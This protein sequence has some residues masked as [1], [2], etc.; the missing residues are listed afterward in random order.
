MRS[1][2]TTSE[3][4]H[5]D[6]PGRFRPPGRVSSQ[7]R[8]YYRAVSTLGQKAYEQAQRENY[9]SCPT[10]RGASPSFLRPRRRLDRFTVSWLPTAYTWSKRFPEPYLLLLLSP[11]SRRA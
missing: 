4:L 6:I 5:N 8:Q 2:W 10:F 11:I 3:Y 1:S 9:Q 7:S